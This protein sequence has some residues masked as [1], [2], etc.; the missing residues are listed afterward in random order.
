MEEE[1]PIISGLSEGVDVFGMKDDSHLNTASGGGAG[2]LIL[3]QETARFNGRGA[4][5]L[6]IC[7]EENGSVSDS[8]GARERIADWV[9]V[10]E[11]D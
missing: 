6:Y 1:S 2:S 3:N 11:T 10:D 8:F 5:A 9:A 4:G 7:E